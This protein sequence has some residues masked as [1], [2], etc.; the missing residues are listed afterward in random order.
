MSALA[1]EVVD[2]IEA[3]EGEWSNHAAASRRELGLGW[4]DVM[5]VAR[6]ADSWKREVDELR[7]AVDGWKDSLTGRDT[8]GRKLFMTG[9]WVYFKGENCW[10]VVTIREHQK[11][12]TQ[13]AKTRRH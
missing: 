2:R 8:Y 12:K 5:A 3:C 10:Y 4:S 9:K 1:P 6:T 13:R 11:Q 7:V